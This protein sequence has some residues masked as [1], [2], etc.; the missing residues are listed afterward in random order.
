MCMW[1][2][3]GERE[4]HS[5]YQ[6]YSLLLLSKKKCHQTLL[7]LIYPCMKLGLYNI[8]DEEIDGEAFL[9]LTVDQ[10]KSLGKTMGPQTKLIMKHRMMLKESNSQVC[11][12]RVA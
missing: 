10:L 4:S 6:N 2:G 1:G 11:K 5:L 3:V 7:V 8:T 9:G 12:R